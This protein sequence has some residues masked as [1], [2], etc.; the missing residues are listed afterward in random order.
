M[1]IIFVSMETWIEFFSFFVTLKKECDLLL[2]DSFFF[3]EDCLVSSYLKYLT[4]VQVRF[5]ISKNYFYLPMNL[6]WF[7]WW[8]NIKTSEIPSSKAGVNGIIAE[9]EQSIMIKLSR[10]PALTRDITKLICKNWT[11]N[12]KSKRRHSCWESCSSTLTRLFLNRPVR[13]TPVSSLVT[14]VEFS[15]ADSS[16]SVS[17]WCKNT[18]IYKKLT[19]GIQW[20]IF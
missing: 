3:P 17:K 19:S 12:E 1:H 14:S 7:W 18:W 20:K 8:E 6:P 2:K 10:S 13:N 5:K 16:A 4:D 11:T 9:V 15:I